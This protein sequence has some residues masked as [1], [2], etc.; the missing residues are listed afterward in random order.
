MKTFGWIGRFFLTI[1]IVAAAVIVAIVLWRHYEDRPWTRDG[2]VVVDVV[3]VAPDVGGLITA[4]Y[5]RDNQIVHR[6]QSLF[7]VDRPRYEDALSQTDANISSAKATLEQARRVAKRDLALGDLVAT[8]THEQNVAAVETAQATLQQAQSMRS[9][10]ELNLRRTNVLASVDGIVTN[11]DLHPGDYVGAGT[12]AMALTDAR[13]L[14]I[15]GYF[16]ETKL[17]RIRIGD[18]AVIHLM[19]DPRDLYG[20]VESFA[21]AIADQENTDTSNLLPSVNPT[22]TWVRLAQRVPVRI[23]IDRMPVGT[24]LISGRTATV[25]IV[26]ARP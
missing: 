16:E 6:G 21:A 8:E 10:A 15:E 5:V 20:H 17:H 2:H 22:F 7:V 12:Q 26:P 23:R 18:H 13:S 11:V 25:S 19:G 9:T 1:A 3:R 4:V 14:R 24:R